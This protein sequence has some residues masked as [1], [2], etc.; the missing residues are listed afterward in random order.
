M[1]KKLWHCARLARN[2][3]EKNVE[4]DLDPKTP[5]FL[6]TTMLYDA[7]HILSHVRVRALCDLCL[8]R[9]PPFL[10]ANHGSSGDLLEME[11]EFEGMHMCCSIQARGKHLHR[12]IISVVQIRIYM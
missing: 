6:R 8:D 1:K 5:R 11:H 12:S 9:A 3:R 4:G 10:L 7:V 2:E